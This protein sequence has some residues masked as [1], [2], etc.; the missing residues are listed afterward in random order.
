MASHDWLKNFDEEVGLWWAT[1]APAHTAP[2]AYLGMKVHPGPDAVSRLLLAAE[3]GELA[4]LPVERVLGTLAKMMSKDRPGELCWYWED[5]EKSSDAN[6]S[7]FTGM[8]LIALWL[9]YQEEL[10]ETSRAVLRSIFHSLLGWFAPLIEEEHFQ[11]LNGYMGEA[12]CA[13]LLSEILDRRSDRT[14]LSGHLLRAAE[15]W[16]EHGFGFGEHLS[17]IYS[18]VALQEISFLLLFSKELPRPLRDRLERVFQ[19]LL[20]INDGFSGGPYVPT[21]RC[22]D[23][24]ESPSKG[25]NR[26]LIAE[27]YRES[28]RPTG[29][30]FEE[31][32]G[33]NPPL[34]GL[35]FK[36][37]WHDLAPTREE[38]A[39]EEFIIPCQR[40][41]RAY[42]SVTKDFRLG[43]LTRFPVMPEV[44]FREWGMSWQSFPVAFWR[45]EGDWGY[46]QWEH[47]DPDGNFCYPSEGPSSDPL[48]RGNPLTRVLP[49]I[50]AKT[51][52]LQRGGD[53][54]VL[55]MMTAVDTRWLTIKDRLRLVDSHAVLEEKNCEN[56]WSQL[57]LRYPERCISVQHVNLMPDGPAPTTVTSQT[58]IV[59][60]ECSWP[61][62]KLNRTLLSLWAISLNGPV[63][64]A[65]QREAER[66]RSAT[67]RHP[68]EYPSLLWWDW[69]WTRW[70]LRIDPLSANPLEALT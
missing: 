10:S 43:S 52:S 54:I 68:E 44:E 36:A 33:N 35:L 47:E 65:P 22:Y 3:R 48:K 20:E 21:I 57:L 46:L 19:T 18:R 29:D 38:P 5:E 39:G 49:P 63:T 51:F 42:A 24:L 32:I 50:L 13:W 62:D 8:G 28:I 31:E 27:T 6:A 67:T 7:F 55:R 60:W 16:L 15:D 58:R 4:K 56:G 34:N 53:L 9:G 66:P 26:L 40:N 17:D 41:S 30:I 1:K 11:C 64:A 23:F 14:A 2:L 69:G 37:G 25:K 61:V 70:D 12:T 59:D 45:P